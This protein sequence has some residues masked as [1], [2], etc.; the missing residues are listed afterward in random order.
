MPGVVV[1]CVWNKGHAAIEQ[2]RTLAIAPCCPILRV[3]L[4]HLESIMDTAVLVLRILAAKVVALHPL[5]SARL[6]HNIDPWNTGVIFKMDEAEFTSEQRLLHVTRLLLHPLL[7][8]SLSPFLPPSYCLCLSPPL[9][10]PPRPAPARLRF[11]SLRSNS[12][13]SD[14]TSAAA[15]AVASDSLLRRGERAVTHSSKY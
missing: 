3:L 11:A 8:P 12:A 14:S 1:V 4:P 13:A 9:S 15:P 5:K 10:L 7:P 6:C 2:E